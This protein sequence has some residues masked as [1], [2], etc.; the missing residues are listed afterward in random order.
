M[1]CINLKYMGIAET[2]CHINFLLKISILYIFVFCPSGKKT[3]ICKY[4]YKDTVISQCLDVI[5][6]SKYI[7]V[8]MYACFTE[9]T[10]R[11]NVVLIC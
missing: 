10:L 1:E 5:V 9:G 2:L 8:Y 4:I 11:L 7:Y 3:A 6:L